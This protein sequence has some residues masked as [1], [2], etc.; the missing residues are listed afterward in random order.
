MFLLSVEKAGRLDGQ[1]VTNNLTR[2][3]H[4][5]RRKQSHQNPHTILHLFIVGQGNFR[6]VVAADGGILA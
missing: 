3:H 5:G 6:L 1:G 4:P 2:L